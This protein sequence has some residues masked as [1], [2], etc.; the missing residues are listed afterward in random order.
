[1]SLESDHLLKEDSKD[2]KPEAP[3]LEYGDYVSLALAKW[4]RFLLYSSTLIF[5]QCWL[6]GNKQNLVQLQ[7]V[8]KGYT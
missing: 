2:G 5:F 8:N 1:V 7:K 3:S 6:V 4:D